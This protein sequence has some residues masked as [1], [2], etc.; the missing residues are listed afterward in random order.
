MLSQ[1]PDLFKA[2][3]I[4]LIALVPM[5]QALRNALSNSGPQDSCNK[6]FYH[7]KQILALF[8]STQYVNMMEEMAGN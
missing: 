7:H 8:S 2:V 6:S 4:P 5:S 1:Y 3:T